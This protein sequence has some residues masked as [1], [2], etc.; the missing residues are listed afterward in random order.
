MKSQITIIIEHDE[1]E[2]A[3]YLCVSLDK[4]VL[5]LSQEGND[6]RLISCQNETIEEKTDA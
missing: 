1:E 6:F 4:K 2:I 5:R 3:D